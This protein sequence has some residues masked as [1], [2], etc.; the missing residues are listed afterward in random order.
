MNAVRLRRLILAL[1]VAG[2]LMGASS[3]ALLAMEGSRSHAQPATRIATPRSAAAAAGGERPAISGDGR[4]VAF[5][6]GAP[7]LTAADTPARDTN[8]RIDVFVRDRLRDETERVSV[9]SDNRKGNG[10][11]GGAAISAD[12]RF[13]AFQSEASDLVAGD[14]NRSTDV[15]V[16]D[17]V[18]RTT[19]RVS[20]G[21][22]GTQSNGSSEA[23]AISGDGRF[24]AFTSS[25]SRL[26]AED[27]NRERDV[28]VRDLWQGRTERVSVD[29]AVRQRRRESENF[30]QAISAHGRVVAFTSWDV[31]ARDRSRRETHL[32]TVSSGGGDAEGE[33]FESAISADGRFVTFRSDASNLTAL[34]RADCV[35]SDGGLE[36]CADVFVR[37]LLRHKTELVSVSSSGKRGN[38]DSFAGTISANGRFVAF[39]S[40]AS[41]LVARD[42]NGNCDAGNDCQ[43][44]FVR[45][46]L[47]RTTQR[48][49]LSSAGKQANQESEFPAISANGRFVAFQSSASNLVVGDKNDV[50]DVFV[51]DRVTKTTELVTVAAA[52]TA[53]A[54]AVA[55][56][57]KESYAERRVL[58]KVRI[59]CKRVHPVTRKDKTCDLETQVKER[60]RR[61][62]LIADLHKTI[63]T[64][65]EGS[66]EQTQAF[67]QLSELN[68]QNFTP[69]FFLARIRRG[70][71]L[72]TARCTGTGRPDRSHERFSQFRCS[73]HVE[74]R[75]MPL[76]VRVTGRSTFRWAIP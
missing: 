51:R 64:A 46:R 48:M 43:D 47:K 66:W 1:V 73:A 65:K 49:S 52:V 34:D 45:D 67:G 55:S 9:S 62:A 20:L 68:H 37:D 25:A 57:W 23:V 18:M 13:V 6:S 7:N 27:T 38:G 22:G 36:P 41:N 33:S 54:G 72:A 24:V 53:G 60:K 63:R 32:V 74:N 19:R 16:R 35:G 31:Y 21:R 69:E 12:G 28:F 71:P 17:R 61:N 3:S 8:A 30:Q 26:V 40:R 75:S 39:Q 44:V 15:F 56:F 50:T 59:P 11:S 42:T 29:A 76:A 70:Y 2:G 58:A 10:N 5:E 14:T 4:F